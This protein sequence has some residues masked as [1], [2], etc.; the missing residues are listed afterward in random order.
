MTADSN[1]RWTPKGLRRGIKPVYEIGR[2][3]FSIFPLFPHR[4]LSNHSIMQAHNGVPDTFTLSGD[5][6]ARVAQ[7]L[8]ITQQHA[9]VAQAAATP[10]VQQALTEIEDAITDQ[11]AALDN[12]AEDDWADA[13]ASGDAEHERRSWR[14]Q[15]AA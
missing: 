9:R 11:L 5:Y 15:R 2:R 7:L 10:H 6:D 13:E 12:A 14:P 3:T 4:R 8:R 1:D